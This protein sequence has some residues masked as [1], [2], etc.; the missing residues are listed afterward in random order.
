MT[1]HDNEEEREGMIEDPLKAYAEAKW[2]AC[3]QAMD[4]LQNK[5]GLSKE[6]AAQ[7]VADH[8]NAEI[9]AN[10]YGRSPI[11]ESR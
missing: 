7:M 6:E 11:G 2:E 4:M 9:R 10:F 8:V 5:Y 1:H 3:K